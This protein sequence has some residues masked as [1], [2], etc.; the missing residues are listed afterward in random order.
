M[1]QISVTKKL[2]F[3][4]AHRLGSDMGRCHNIH[5]HNYVVDLTVEPMSLANG[6]SGSVVDFKHIKDI[7]QKHLDDYYDHRLFLR[8][9]DSLI[10]LLA[11]ADI[12]IVVA[13]QYPTAE[14]MA[15]HFRTVFQNLLPDD[16]RVAN[17]TV[18][19]TETS[20]ATIGR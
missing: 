14:W 7:C 5:G 16:L 20:F 15:K 19:E 17:V 12:D 10:P 1:D 13:G 8:T 18:W 6:P 2:R 3:C 11:G 9:G 4:C